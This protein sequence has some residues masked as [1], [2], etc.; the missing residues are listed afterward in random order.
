MKRMAAVLLAFTV[1]TAVSWAQDSVF[2]RQN[3]TKHEYQ[4]TMRD[5][6]KLFTIVYTP[7][8]M[9]ESHPILMTRTPYSVAPYGPDNYYTHLGDLTR[10]YFERNYIMVFQDVRGRYMS[11]GTYVNVRPYIPNKKSKKDID[12]TLSTLSLA[13][14]FRKAM[15]GTMNKA[16][17]IFIGPR[18]A[19]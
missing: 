4:I 14:G 12:E 17:T 11:E 16:S 19:A 6:I 15:S 18:S 3:Y 1:L 13:S 5:G 7:K 10:K 9:S 8:D 2:V